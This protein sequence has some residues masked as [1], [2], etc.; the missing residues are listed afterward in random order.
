MNVSK[1][2]KNALDNG[3]ELEFVYS[4]KNK[5]AVG[6]RHVQPVEL[7]NGGNV[8]VGIDLD[9]DGYRRF[10]LDNMTNVRER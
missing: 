4:N 8:L 9:K 10:I 5:N 6:V 2:V 3:V 7:I 1:I